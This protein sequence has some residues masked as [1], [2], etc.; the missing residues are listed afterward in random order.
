MLAAWSWASVAR[1]LGATSNC[2][3]FGDTC[4]GIGVSASR[5]AGLSMLRKGSVE[6][7]PVPLPPFLASFRSAICLR[8]DSRDSM[9]SRLLEAAPGAFCTL[10]NPLSILIVTREDDLPKC[11]ARI[12]KPCNSTGPVKLVSGCPLSAWNCSANSGVQVAKMDVLVL[13]SLQRYTSDL[14][15]CHSKM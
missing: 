13:P 5:W 2:R 10:L 7:S 11:A 8:I 3:L 6:A 1:G 12:S 4:G 9:G 14:D 15:F